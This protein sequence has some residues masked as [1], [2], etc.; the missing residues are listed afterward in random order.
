MDKQEIIKKIE[1]EITERW[2]LIASY[3]KS[4]NASLAWSEKITI[5]GLSI[6]IKI[7]KQ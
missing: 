5:E 4:G 6:A 3:R 1:K 7:I 2:V